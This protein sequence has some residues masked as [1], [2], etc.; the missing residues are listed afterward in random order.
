MP[1]H[2]ASI[3]FSH[4]EGTLA[5]FRSHQL[6]ESLSIAVTSIRI[7]VPLER[8]PGASCVSRGCAEFRIHETMTTA[9][10][11]SMQALAP[12]VDQLQAIAQ[13]EIPGPRTC[14]IRLYDDHTYRI[15][16]EH[17]RCGEGEAIVYDRVTGEVYWRDSDG[18][19][20]LHILDPVSYELITTTYFE[21][22]AEVVVTT[23][24]PPFECEPAIRDCSNS[25]DVDQCILWN[26]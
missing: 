3:D 8:S 19:R 17:S 21:D 14:R 4:T 1:L 24:D 22:D 5:A 12:L 15:T 25:A 10:M 16:I 11:P 23:I 6:R 9:S 13:K 18:A 20:R 26:H 7:T 2:E